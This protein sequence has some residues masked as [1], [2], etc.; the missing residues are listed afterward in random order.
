MATTQIATVSNDPQLDD[1]RVDELEELLDEYVYG[2][3]A[4]DET[5]AEVDREPNG[6]VPHLRLCGYAD[7]APVVRKDRFELIN[8]EGDRDFH[9]DTRHH[10]DDTVEFLQRLSEFLESPL[11]I[12]TV[13]HTKLRFPGAFGQF[14][15]DPDGT[16]SQW[17]SDAGEGAV[18]KRVHQPDTDVQS[19]GRGMASTPD[20]VP[21]E[22]DLL[23]TIADTVSTIRENRPDDPEAV[24]YALDDLERCLGDLPID[25]ETVARM[26]G[27]V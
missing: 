12:Q 4:H 10:E 1:D 21:V 24:S 5:T 20:T 25:E 16:V 26:K 8:E 7:F 23:E 2:T 13:S 15:V 19:E 18:R 3:G 17:Y 14:R 6:G 27:A 9:S 11:V 22:R